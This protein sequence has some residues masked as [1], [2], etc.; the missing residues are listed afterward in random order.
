LQAALE[1]CEQGGQEDNRKLKALE[2][3]LQQARYETQ[4]SRRQYDAAEPEN[5][6]V[7]GE[8]EKRWEQA[9]QL[10]KQAEQAL[11]EARKKSEQLSQQDRLRLAA[12]AEDLPHV[13]SHQAAPMEL[14]KRIV[15]CALTSITAEEVEDPPRIKLLLHWAGGVHTTVHVKR[16][17]TGEHSRCTDREVIELVR[18]LAASHDDRVIAQVLNRLGYTTG[19]CN[20]F[21]LDRVQSLR[22]YHKIPCSDNTKRDWLTL[23]EAS[24][25]LKLNQGTVRKFLQRGLLQGRQIVKHAPWMIRP[26]ALAEPGVQAAAAKVHAG[27]SVPPAEQQSGL[28]WQPTTDEV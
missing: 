25:R 11:D 9:L 26:D 4:R 18:E 22:Q 1:A 7:C 23:E 3:A 27:S 24:E 2:M 15:R 16:N 19:A 8:L 14:K 13:W 28:L 12:L 5:R 6:L 20:S 10:E 17:R 21:N